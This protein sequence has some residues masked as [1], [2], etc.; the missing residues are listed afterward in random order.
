MKDLHS[1]QMAYLGWGTGWGNGMHD[2]PLDHDPPLYKVL[3]SRGRDARRAGWFMR[4]AATVTAISNTRPAVNRTLSTTSRH[5]GDCVS[6]MQ[7][8]AENA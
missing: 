8:C 6:S 1:I 2:P 3:R 4:A 5:K 7:Q